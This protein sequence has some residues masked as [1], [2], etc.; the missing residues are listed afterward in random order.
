MIGRL[1]RI[2]FALAIRVGA[3]SA[4]AAQE[5]PAFVATAEAREYLGTWVVDLD[6]EMGPFRFTIQV[7]DADGS[8][9]GKVLA[10]VLGTKQ[11]LVARRISKRGNDLRVDFTGEYEGVSYPVT[12]YIIPTEDGAFRSSMNVADGVLY[13]SGTAT[14]S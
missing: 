14:K 8:L 5:A 11:E 13:G 12:I 7:E 10:E 2:L 3:P 4:L 6:T 9:A 1:A